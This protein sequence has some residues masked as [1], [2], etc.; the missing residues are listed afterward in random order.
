MKPIEFAS[1]SSQNTP[2]R[3]EALAAQR[4]WLATG[5]VPLDY[6]RDEVRGAFTNVEVP[7]RVLEHALG[8]S[9]PPS[10]I[11]SDAETHAETSIASLVLGAAE[12]TKALAGL[13]VDPEADRRIEKLMTE[14]PKRGSKKPLPRK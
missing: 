10:S 8:L 11:P 2:V 6:L 3:E 12:Q 14:Q 5:A 7:L 13:P 4:Q 1:L 9:T